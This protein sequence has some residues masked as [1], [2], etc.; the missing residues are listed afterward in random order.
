[1]Y[2][3]GNNLSCSVTLENG[4]FHDESRDKEFAEKVSATLYLFERI[5]L[6]DNI[7]E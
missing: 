2:N 3:W 6:I 4:F 5:T 7:N 1:M